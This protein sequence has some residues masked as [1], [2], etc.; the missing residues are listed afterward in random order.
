MFALIVLSFFF[1]LCFNNDKHSGLQLC[2]SLINIVTPKRLCDG[3]SNEGANK[4]LLIG[5]RAH[6]HTKPTWLL[7]ETPLFTWLQTFCDSI[8][9]EEKDNA[10][11]SIVLVQTNA[12]ELGQWV[13]ITFDGEFVFSLFCLLQIWRKSNF[14]FEFNSTPSS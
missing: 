4:R 13:I 14:D 1:S 5:A 12:M 7:R 6:A 11:S 9:K 2:S 10:S 3:I 8:G